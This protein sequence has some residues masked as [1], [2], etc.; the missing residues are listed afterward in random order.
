MQITVDDID[1][2]GLVTVTLSQNARLFFSSL[3]T[4]EINIS[5]RSVA[6]LNRPTHEFCVLGLEQV[7]GST[8]E[9]IGNVTVN[10]PDCG[11]AV[12]SDADDALFLKGSVDITIGTVQITGD[13]V[14]QGNTT[15]WYDTLRTNAPRTDDPYADWDVEEYKGGCTG[16]ESPQHISASGTVT[17]SPGTYCG[18]LKISGTNDVI[19]EPGVYVM[20]GGDF[21]VSGGGTLNGEGVS[22]IFT[23][24]TEDN[25]GNLNV[26]GN[27]Y[28]TFSAPPEGEEMEGVVF[29]Q[30]R[31]AP[32]ESENKIVG[33]STIDIDGAAY[34]PSQQ[35][36]F[37]GNSGLLDTGGCV[38]LIARIVSFHGNP[39]LTNNCEGNSPLPIGNLFVNLIQ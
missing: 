35:L 17:V 34:F 4:Q 9:V 16:N 5:A 29:F 15:F 36:R 2:P 3:F 1:D 8:V 10:S 20:D 19:F 12:N 6:D 25:Y 21:D 26:S 13:Y 30:D 38:K 11:I 32:T 31:N 33:T 14:E 23:S 7:E 39:S 18:G 28:V 37:G 22:F 24:S 27:K